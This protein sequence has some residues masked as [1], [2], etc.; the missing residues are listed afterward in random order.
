MAIVDADGAALRGAGRTMAIAAV[1]AAALSGVTLAVTAGDGEARFDDVRFNA[2]GVYTLQANAPGLLPASTGPIRVVAAQDPGLT[3]VAATAPVQVAVTGSVA[4]TLPSG[5]QPGD[6]LLLVAVNSSL[7]ATTP[8]VGWTPLVDLAPTKPAEFRFSVWW[9]TANA[10]TTTALAHVET[11]AGGAALWSLR[12]RRPAGYPPLPGLAATAIQ[13]GTANPSATMT[14][15]PDLTTHGDEAT[16]LSL[17]AARAANPLSIAPAN[18]FVLRLASATSTAQGM[19]LGLA[20]RRVTAS[21][22]TSASPT[23]SR[24]GSA[25]QWAWVTVAFR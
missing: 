5:T 14:P 23:W 20:D 16:V 13:T 19:A 7:H 22:T 6:L 9:R 10:A 24:S 2:P 21:G 3:F 25:G 4:V 12:Y 8:E 15:A 17:V 1:G 18:G 11:G